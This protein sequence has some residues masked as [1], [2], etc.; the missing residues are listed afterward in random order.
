MSR[1]IPR[2][3]PVTNAIFSIAPES[4]RDSVSLPTELTGLTSEPIVLGLVTEGSNEGIC[5]HDCGIRRIGRS[6]YG[7]LQRSRG[8][9]NRGRLSRARR[10]GEPSLGASPDRPDRRVF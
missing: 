2:P 7:V 10:A 4:Y 1:P 3:A 8:G 6:T 5:D 9:T